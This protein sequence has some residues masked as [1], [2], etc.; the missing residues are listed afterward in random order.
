MS[1]NEN[2]KIGDLI[3]ANNHRFVICDKPAGMPVQE[4]KTGDKSLLSLA[5]IF[6][7]TRLH[8]VNRIDRPVKGLVIFAK[9]G[10]NATLLSEMLADG[11][12]EKWYL[13][14]T[15]NKPEKESATL[16]QWLIHDKKTNKSYIYDTKLPSSKPARL[17]YNIIG[18]ST[19]YHYWLVRLHTGRHHQIRA[20]LASLNCPVKGD[21]KYGD[22]RA[23]PDKSISLL[24][25]K[26]NF[27]NPLHPKVTEISSTLPDDALWNHLNENILPVWIAK[28]SEL[29]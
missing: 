19:N 16:E 11:R 13:G 1:T 25:W 26:L 27:I 8:P 14:I 15:R 9:D 20:Q 3:L 12:I 2:F 17:D 7:K 18:S 10:K 4:D 28:L 24:A 29:K 22:K 6:C 23:N 5:E 21:V